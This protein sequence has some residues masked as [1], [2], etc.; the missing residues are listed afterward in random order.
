MS[1]TGMHHMVVR[2]KDFDEGVKTWRDRFGLELD[3]TAVN[4]E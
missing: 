2:V 1:F 4:R 3:R